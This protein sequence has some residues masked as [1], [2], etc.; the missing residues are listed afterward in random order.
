MF[1]LE[2]GIFMVLLGMLY[3]D[4]KYRAIYWWLFPILS[5]LLACRSLEAITLSGILKQALQSA[6]FLLLQ[7]TAL[8]VYLSFKERKLTN[9]FNG[10]FGLGDLLFLVSITF[11]FSFLN[12]I[13]F[14][15]SSLT[16]IILFTAILNNINKKSTEKIPLAGYQALLAIVLMMIDMASPAIDLLSDRSLILM[17]SYGN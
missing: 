3:Q 9:I 17:L 5:L 10:F 8:T 6:I 14:Y 7:F 12:Y 1:F 16:L 11:G 13:L 15:L 2:G 4:L